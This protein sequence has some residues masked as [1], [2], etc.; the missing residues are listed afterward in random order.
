MSIW[1]LIWKSF[2][3]LKIKVY[4][5]VCMNL[6][7][8]LACLYIYTWISIHIEYEFIDVFF[9]KKYECKSVNKSINLYT[10]LVRCVFNISFDYYKCNYI[11]GLLIDLLFMFWYSYLFPSMCFEFQYAFLYWFLNE[12]HVICLF[13]FIYEFKP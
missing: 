6:R 10:D 13:D 11:Y 12:C 5:S 2:C 3:F 7:I 9:Q 8:N 1:V 4:I